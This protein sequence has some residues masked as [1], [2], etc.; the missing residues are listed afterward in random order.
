M[1]IKIIFNY[2]IGYI[3]I[4]VEGY[5]IERFI[6]ICRNNKIT[7]WNL[8]RDKNVKLELNIGIRDL[9]KVAKIAKQTKC[10]LKITRKRGLPFVFN[11]YKKRKLFFVF[12]I[13]LIS[14]LAIA[15]NFIWNIEIIEENEKMENIY[16]D[17]VES[18]V[19]NRKNENKNKHKRYYKQNTIKKK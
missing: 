18:G 14:I 1:L 2:I 9:K 19:R 17:V 3:R 15:S 5:Y 12:L 16:Q 4:S 10:K 8:K 7:I 6:N 13:V 11:K